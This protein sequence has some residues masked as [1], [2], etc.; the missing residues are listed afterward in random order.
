MVYSVDR[1]IP[2]EGVSE[3]MLETVSRS[4][5]YRFKAQLQKAD[6]KGIY[7]TSSVVGGTAG[8][9]NEGPGEGFEEYISE[10]VRALL[11]EE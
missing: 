9:D 11:K 10:T 5:A 8:G 3:V 6:P 2:G 7:G 1:T 4:K